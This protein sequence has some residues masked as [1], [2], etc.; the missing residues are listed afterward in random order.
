MA[1][2]SLCTEQLSAINYYSMFRYSVYEITEIRLQLLKKYSNVK[3][4]I[5]RYIKSILIY[6]KIRYFFST[7]RYDT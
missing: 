6:R 4:K 3:S 2:E 1:L 7:I 5:S